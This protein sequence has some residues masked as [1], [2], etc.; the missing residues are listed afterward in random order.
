MPMMAPG[1]ELTVLID[2]NEVPDSLHDAF[3]G[4]KGY[5][6]KYV[7]IRNLTSQ[8]DW[9]VLLKTAWDGRLVVSFS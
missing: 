6:A 4:F 2:M 5:L 8:N 1:E 9:P 7:R 3:V